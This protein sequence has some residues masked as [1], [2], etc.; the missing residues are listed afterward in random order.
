[1]VMGGTGNSGDNYCVPNE[2][3]Q[4]CDKCTANAGQTNCTGDIYKKR[5]L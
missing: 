5:T 1:M 4:T 3:T 2:V